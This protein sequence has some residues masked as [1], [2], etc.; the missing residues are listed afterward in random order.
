M[1]GRPLRKVF[2]NAR[3]KFDGLPCQAKAMKNGK[4]KLH[5]GMS[6]GQKTINGK[7]KAYQNLNPFKEW[8]VDKIREYVERKYLDKVDGRNTIDQ[9][10]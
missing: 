3:R 1:V 2:C 10:L 9:D 5:G 4:C 7:V 6:S 8:S